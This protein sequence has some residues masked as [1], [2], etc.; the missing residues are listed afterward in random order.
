MERD[1]Y[2]RAKKRASSFKYGRIISGRRLD[3]A[4][5]SQEIRPAAALLVTDEVDEEKYNGPAPVVLSTNRLQ[6]SAKSEKDDDGDGHWGR[7]SELLLF[8]L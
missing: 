6:G 2:A 5:N 1:Q 4:P 8:P 3:A 7:L